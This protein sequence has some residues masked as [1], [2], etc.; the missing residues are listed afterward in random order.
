MPLKIPDR[1]KIRLGLA[2]LPPGEYGMPFLMEMLH[3]AGA[4][5][6]GSWSRAKNHLQE[7]PL[8]RWNGV[9]GRG[10]RW[11]K[12]APEPPKSLPEYIPAKATLSAE[13]HTPG[14]VTTCLNKME[15][16]MERLCAEWKIP[17]DDIQ[18]R[19]DV[20]AKAIQACQEVKTALEAMSNGDRYYLAARTRKTLLAFVNAALK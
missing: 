16:M 7:D 18:P 8:W 9:K 2:G 10:S 12:A 4:I 17:T 5:G 14:P 6:W 19:A 15:V 11:I 3:N 1:S 13:D 20:N